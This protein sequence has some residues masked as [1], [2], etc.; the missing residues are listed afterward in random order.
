ML[1]RHDLES[2]FPEHRAKLPGIRAANER[3]RA[4]ESDYASLDREI[5]T[6]EENGIPITDD[7][8]MALKRRRLA[9]KEQLDDMLKAWR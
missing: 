8:F 7:H 6:A 1:Q 2:E 9:L 5:L 3:F 4:I